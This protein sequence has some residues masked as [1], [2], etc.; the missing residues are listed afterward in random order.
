[1]NH[2]IYINL[3]HICSKNEVILKGIAF[4]LKTSTE[5][6]LKK[7]KG[8]ED[9]TFQEAEKISC[10]LNKPLQYIFFTQ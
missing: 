7:I 1:M 9:F 3:N 4:M 8:D 2:P 10:F 6:I 5:N